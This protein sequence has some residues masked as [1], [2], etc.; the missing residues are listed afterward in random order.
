MK[1]V[2]YPN[3]QNQFSSSSMP[4]FSKKIINYNNLAIMRL[5]SLPSYLA[6]VHLHILY[7]IK[8]LIS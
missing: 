7:K 2:Y 1:I 5:E 3:K 4:L 8:N 6:I